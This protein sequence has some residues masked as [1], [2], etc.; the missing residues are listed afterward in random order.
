MCVACGAHS[1]TAEYVDGLIQVILHFAL[2]QEGR[3]KGWEQPPATLLTIALDLIPNKLAEMSIL[4]KGHPSCHTVYCFHHTWG[5]Y[6]TWFPRPVRCHVTTA[7]NEMLS[8]PASPINGPPQAPTILGTGVLVCPCAPIPHTPT[9]AH[10]HQTPGRS[11]GH[12]DPHRSWVIRHQGLLVGATA[13]SLEGAGDMHV[14]GH[15]FE[16]CA[17]QP[18]TGRSRAGSGVPGYNAQTGHMGTPTPAGRSKGLSLDLGPADLAAPSLGCAPRGQ[19]TSLHLSYHFYETHGEG[20]SFQSR[21][22]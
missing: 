5:S 13:M 16:V 14:N 12:G 11:P 8:Q 22:T 4:V 7:E 19:V 21:R 10:P 9:M 20:G 15:R 1:V 6:R 3:V 2:L 18:N 17:T